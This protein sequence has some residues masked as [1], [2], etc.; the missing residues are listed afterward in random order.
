[1]PLIKPGVHY[2]HKLDHRNGAPKKSQWIIPEQEERD[3]FKAMHDQELFANGIGWGVYAVNASLSQIGFGVDRLRELYI[4]KFV[5]GNSN[6][7]WHGYPA[8][9]VSHNQDIPDSTVLMAWR[10]MDLLTTSKVRKILRGQ[11]CNL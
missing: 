7:H 9:H 6:N 1:M 2:V 11:P 5:D 10:N 4:A 8:D 3:C